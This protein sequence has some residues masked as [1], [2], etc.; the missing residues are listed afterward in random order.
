MNK[1]TF[2]TF[3]S[4]IADARDTLTTIRRADYD[5]A[6]ALG[7]FRGIVD[8]AIDPVRPLSDLTGHSAYWHQPY[9]DAGLRIL[10]ALLALDLLAGG[11]DGDADTLSA[12]H[13]SDAAARLRAFADDA[14]ARLSA[15]SGLA[16]NLAR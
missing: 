4:A 13:C 6:D 9:G 12:T 2:G 16:A 3:A 15:V 11:V 10:D 8:R 1:D 7:R 5:A 14:D